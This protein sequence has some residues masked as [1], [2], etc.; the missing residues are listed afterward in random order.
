MAEVGVVGVAED[1]VGWRIRAPGGV[2]CLIWLASI[3]YEPVGGPGAG[4]VDGLAGGR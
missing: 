4:L 1:S 2:S 3:E